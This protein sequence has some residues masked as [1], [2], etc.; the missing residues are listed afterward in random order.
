MRF[1]WST[2]RPCGRWRGS[3]AVPAQLPVGS[4]SLRATLRLDLSECPGDWDVLQRASGPETRTSIA[5]DR[6]EQADSHGVLRPDFQPVPTGRGERAARGATY[7]QHNPGVGDGKQAFIDY[8]ARMAEEYPG[9]RVEFL[10]AIAEDDY[11]VLHCSSTGRATTTTPAWTS[12]ASTVT[13][14]LWRTGTCSKWSP[15]APTTTTRCSD[16]RT[17]EQLR[18]VCVRD[19][20]A[21]EHGRQQEAP[22][23]TPW[24]RARSTARPT[25]FYEKAKVNWRIDSEGG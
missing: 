14:R 3:C 24:L 11:V 23:S 25:D 21:H 6:A 15:S 17:P 8:F 4:L 18:C 20:A 22:S 19:I 5:S 1:G 12:S 16:E 10:R 7:I 9:T 2:V 13:A